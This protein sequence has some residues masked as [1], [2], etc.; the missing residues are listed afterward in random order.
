M[1]QTYLRREKVRISQ[2]LTQYRN[3]LEQVKTA[4]SEA[5]LAVRIIELEAAEQALQQRLL[6]PFE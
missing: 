5:W 4:E 1:F 3:A 6:L 2:D